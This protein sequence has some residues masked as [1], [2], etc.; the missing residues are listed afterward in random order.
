MSTT[1]Q[2]I[3]ILTGEQSHTTRINTGVLGITGLVVSGNLI[4]DTT[5]SISIFSETKNTFFQVYNMGVRDN[6]GAIV[7]SSDLN[8]PLVSDKFI[9]L[10]PLIDLVKAN[11][12]RFEINQAQEND[13]ELIL[14]KGI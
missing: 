7:G 3:K 9:V 12:V 6:E 14:F 8:F 2:S 11:K 4:A 1:E 10:N 5:L 13:I